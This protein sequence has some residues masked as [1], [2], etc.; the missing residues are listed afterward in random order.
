MTLVLLRAFLGSVLAMLVLTASADGIDGDKKAL[1][2]VD[3]MLEKMGGRALWAKAN[4]LYTMERARHPR[5]GDGIVASYWRD[6]EAPGEH[7]EL[8]QEGVDIEYAWT[9]EDGW[10]ERNGEIR[11]YSKEELRSLHDKWHQEIYTLY[12]ELALGER[13]LTVRNLDDDG[14]RV[15]DES[16]RKIA[17]FRLTPD[18]HLYYWTQYEG[19]D[20]R[21]WVYGPYRQFGNISFPDWG[22]S[23]DGK[24]SF[25][26]LQVLP[27]EK[28]FSE[29]TSTKRPRAWEGGALHPQC[30]R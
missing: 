18:G 7:G 21:S 24:W 26:Y 11:E 25:Y 6:F 22:T 29:N 17:D 19:K 10:I 9:T 16:K 8:H 12:H 5:Y 27:S 14:F 15:I 3:L 30:D 2:R 23:A 13:E 1:A 20:A 4:S 28:P